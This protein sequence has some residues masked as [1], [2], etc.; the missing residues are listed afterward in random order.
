V[1]RL[2]GVLERVRGE[3]LVTILTGGVA[4]DRVGYFVQPTVLVGDDPHHEVF[5]T[6]L[7]GPILS[8][9]VYDDA[10]WD[11]VLDLVDTSTPYALTGSV[12]ATDRRAIDAAT[13]RLRFAARNFY[14]HHKPTR[15][16]VGQPAVGGA[17]AR[18]T[19]ATGGAGWRPA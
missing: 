12:L 4:D 5:T 3:G 17:P 7:F 10:E 8:V 19:A 6:E 2:S 16:G 13:H 9:F 1:G 14:V 15:A 18:R 11:A